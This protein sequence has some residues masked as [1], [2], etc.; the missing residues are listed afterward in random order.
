MKTKNLKIL[1]ILLFPILLFAQVREY[2]IHD[3]GMLHETV[4]NTG[5]IGRPWSIADDMNFATTP[6]FEWPPYSKTII[7]GIEYS[8][9]HNIIGGGVYI[10]ANEKGKPG[11]ENRLFAFCGGIGDGNGPVLPLGVWSF[12]ISIEEIENF[13][14]LPDG[15]PNP[16]YNPDEAEEIII[17]KWSTN[18]GITVTR[19]S[20]AWSYPDYD[21][22]IIYE[23]Y[24]VYTGDTDGDLSTIERKVPLVDVLFTV[25]YGFSPSMLGYQRHYGTWK[26][27]GGMW[28]GDNRSSFDPDYFLTYMQTTHTGVQDEKT[29]YL[30][31]KPEPDTTLF[32][33]FSETGLNG[34]GL[35]SPQAAG[36]CWIHWDTTHLAI[37]DPTNPERNQ[38]DYANYMLKDKF[39]KYFE[40]DEHGHIL[41][42]WQM[43]TASGNTRI[44]KMIDRATT[45]DERWWTVYGEVGVSEDM[46]DKGGR[47]VIPKGRTWKGRAR[48][49][50]NESYNGVA[51]TNGFGPYVMELGDTIEFVYAEVV[52]YGGTPGKV[53]CGGQTDK[54]F[55]P[56][57][58][59]DRKVV[60]NGRTMTEHYLTDYGYPDYVNSKVIS[61]SQVAH[62][63]WEA[64]LGHEIPYDSTRKGP[65][66]GMLWPEDTPR[67]SENP[68]KYKIPA[69]A[70]APIIRVENTPGA[71]V[72]VI[73]G[74][75]VEEFSHPR[76]MG[77]VV[78]YN[79]YRSIAAMG[80]WEKLKTIKVGEDGPDGNYEFEDTDENYRLGEIRFYAVTSVD[81][82]GNESGKT[83]I[84]EHRKNV[85]SVEKLGKVYAVPNP[86][87]VKSG[88][89]GNDNKIGFY[90][91]PE[92]CTIRIF[93]YSGQH[94]ATIEHNDPVFSTEWFQITRNDQ[95]IA[96]GIYLYVVTTPSGERSTGKFI[97]VK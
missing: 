80:P 66:G 12:P 54:Q 95:D 57:P 81:E 29:R 86:F 83:N 33:L 68:N 69:V 6:Q 27:E 15:T 2:R 64:Y 1:I 43:K 55:F 32:R 75:E 40:T 31:A 48:Y 52:G 79:V 13:P 28:R 74:H 63:A 34:G 37:V 91:L 17:A 24:L 82:H 56:A 84:T 96:S 36:Y 92:K 62:K 21:D 67:P 47:F 42:P 9:Q 11:N 35:L 58:S 8:G 72:K 19:I 71:T 5:T 46:P 93:S 23:Y 89:E 26:Y 44:S 88:F 77:D 25:N 59:L 97:V 10:T 78:A 53:I 3:R 7:N 39:G 30:L 87:Y 51:I 45:M 22:M 20:R 41:Q 65:A 60:I 14:F 90:G 49:E 4:Y 76:L 16:D 73:W 38:S 85:R 61:V 50:W 94:I 70:P 18:V